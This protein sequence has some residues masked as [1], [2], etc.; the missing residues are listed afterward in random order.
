[1]ARMN[2][3][4]QRREGEA[5]GTGRGTGPG[6]KGAS[7]RQDG[8]L[9]AN[10]TDASLQDPQKGGWS[11]DRYA[12]VGLKAQEIVVACDDM[13]GVTFHSACQYGD[14]VGV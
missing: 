4:G 3:H 2:C 7:P 8:L 9:R 14:I 11:D 1:M 12:F 10:E 6:R 13:V 5:Y